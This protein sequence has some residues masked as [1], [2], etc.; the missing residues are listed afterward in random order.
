MPWV[1][2]FDLGDH[3]LETAIAATNA[4][5]NWIDNGR[6]RRNELL[7]LFFPALWA[8]LLA[9]LVVILDLEEFLKDVVASLAHV[10]IVWHNESTIYTT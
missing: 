8:G 7:H 5:T 4:Q 2:L 1:R 3:F 10:I 6:C 9:W